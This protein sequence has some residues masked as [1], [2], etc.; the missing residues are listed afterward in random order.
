M[1]SN[2]FFENLE[3]SGRRQFLKKAGKN[4]AVA[5]AVLAT[6]GSESEA[7]TDTPLADKRRRIASNSYAIRQLFKRRPFSPRAG[8]SEERRQR[9]EHFEAA[10]K[11]LKAKYGEITMLDLPQF[12]KDT[13]EGASRIDVWSS[14]FG[15]VTDSS[16]FGTRVRQG[17]TLPGEFDPS[18][19]SAKKWLDQLAAK[20]ASTG[21]EV[22][23]ISNN[24]PRNLSVLDKESRREGIRVGKIWLEAARQIGARSMRVNTGGPRIVPC[25]TTETGYPQNDEIVALLKAGI[26]SFKELADYGEEMGVKVT[27]ENHWGLSA[28]PM[29]VL[30]ILN[31]VNSAYCEASPDYCNWEHEYMLYHGLEAL[32]P[33]ASSMCHAK[34]WSRYPNVD[35]ARCTRILS[36]A[37]YRGYVSLEYETS[38]LDDD[39]VKGTLKLMEDVVAAL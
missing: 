16:Q 14:L 3:K 4:L 18:K 24:A 8:M 22:Q 5:G 28:H 15:D 32:I 27:I 9:M 35:I 6:A 29:N 20:T 19:T 31:E 34:R 23:H 1:S 36:A 33:Y 12:T 11:K 10:G 2:E 30:I 17:R 26:E 25:A 7:R 38:G 37:N 21:I 13:Y 39:P